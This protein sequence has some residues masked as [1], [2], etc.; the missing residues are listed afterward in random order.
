MLFFTTERE[1]ICHMNFFKVVQNC[2]DSES[3]N[4]RPSCCTVEQY[5]LRRIPH[6]KNSK[7]SDPD[8]R[9]R[10]KYSRHRGAIAEGQRIRNLNRGG[11][12]RCAFA[13]EEQC[14]RTGGWRPE[15][16]GY[17][18][19]RVSVCDPPALPPSVGCRH[20]WRL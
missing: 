18:G 17:V 20:E 15:Y 1:R 12:L 7:K 10:S 4:G 16:A 2:A 11:W 5:V 19:V 9:G 3:A 6:V 8:S 13:D 14:A